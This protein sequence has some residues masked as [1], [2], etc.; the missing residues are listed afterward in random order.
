MVVTFAAYG[1]LIMLYD[2]CMEHVRW[3]NFIDAKEEPTDKI[4]SFVNWN[5]DYYVSRNLL[6]PLGGKYDSE[7]TNKLIKKY[8]LYIG[9][10]WLWV[11]ILLIAF[12]TTIVIVN[13]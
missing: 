13:I 1:M 2:E 3:Q 4:S 9:L 8:N 6:L 10:F 7:E 12:V 5:A 11:L